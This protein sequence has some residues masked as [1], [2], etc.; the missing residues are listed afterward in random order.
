[1]KKSIAAA[2]LFC[3][4]TLLLPTLVKAQ[5]NIYF[6][7]KGGI[8]I[9]NLSSGSSA[10]TDWDEGYSSRV[11]PNFGLLAEFQFSKTF[12]IQP[13]IDFIG[14][15]GKRSGIQPLSV[16]DQYLPA[17]QGA[18]NTD[19]DYV[20]GDF[21]NVSRINYLQI[22][23]MVKFNFALNQSQRFNF[24][25]QAGPYVSFL[26]SAKQ[27][28]QTDDLKLYLDKQGQQQIPPEAAAAF[29]PSKLDTAIDAKSDLQKTNVG[30]QGGVGLA[31]TINRG[32]IFIEGGGNY[33]FID[34]QKGDEHGKNRIGAATIA[35]GYAVSFGDR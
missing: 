14:E 2:L 21:K 29:F 4:T 1:M 16:P 3:I 24:F 10:Q 5:K 26:V 15:G 30:V 8:S 12:S 35:V 22:P 9:P 11:G 18:F 25:V 23:I 19:K 27:I 28:I 17:F 33:G 32:K 34:I 31:Y 6:G 13:E 20:F 7:L